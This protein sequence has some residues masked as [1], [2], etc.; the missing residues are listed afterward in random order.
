MTTTS[1]S[2]RLAA[3]VTPE[4]LSLFKR[5]AE[6]EGRS[7]SDFVVAAAQRAAHH[8]VADLEVLKLSREAGEPFLNCI[9]QPPAPTEALQ[10]AF[11]RHRELVGRI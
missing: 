10:D 8:A 3:R 6:I 11:A 1:K 7:V 2:A 5:A 9:E 4:T